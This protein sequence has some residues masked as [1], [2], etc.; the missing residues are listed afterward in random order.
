M[1]DHYR[2][3][4]REEIL[5]LSANFTDAIL[6]E[7]NGVWMLKITTGAKLKSFAKGQV[8][9]KA[10][11]TKAKKNRDDKVSAIKAERAAKKEKK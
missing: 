5:A 4:T 6:F 11:F 9:T 7:D 10:N 2:K 3:G 8:E 1:T